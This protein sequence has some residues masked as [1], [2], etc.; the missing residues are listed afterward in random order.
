[1]LAEV[2]DFLSANPELD[3]VS[4]SG[5]GEPTLH[6]GLG[7]IVRHI[8]R[9]F[10]RY[11]LALLT[12]GTLFTSSSVRKA[13]SQVDVILPSLDA[14]SPAAFKLI[15]RPCSGLDPKKIALGLEKLRKEFRGRIWLEIFIVPGINDTPSELKLLK[16]AV[17]KIR[18]DKIQINSLDRPGTEQWVVPADRN[19]LEKIAIFFGKNAEVIASPSSRAAG[20]ACRMPGKT[21]DSVLDTLI[22]RPSTASDLMRIAALD[23]KKLG[24]CL[25]VLLGQGKIVPVFMKRGTFF[26]AVDPS[27]KRK[28]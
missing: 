6:S 24:L 20:S 18:P 5:A 16:A 10:P 26:K 15:N 1:M 9:K 3:Y 7:K 25:K 2:D 17:K 4:F 12:N 8:K 11:K 14:V 22:R 23:K 21:I 27:K 13:V 19:A 28:K